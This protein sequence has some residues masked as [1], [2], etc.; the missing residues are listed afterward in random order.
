VTL[1]AHKN[2]S[3]LWL[4]V[5][6][7]V[8]V[9]CSG[10]DEDDVVARAYGNYLYRS[11]IA[12]LVPEG[13][14]AEDSVVIVNNYVNQWL[15]QQVVLEKARKNVKKNFDKELQN[16]KNSLLAY[17][18]EQLVVAE[19]LDTNV[20][21]EE[22][23]SYYNSHQETFVLRFPLVRAIWVKIPDDKESVKKL[24]SLMS[25]SKLSDDDIM[26][27]QR[28]GAT[29]S[30]GA[31]YDMES[32]RPLYKFLSDVPVEAGGDGSW[33][34]GKR[35]VEAADGDC[36]CMAHIFEFRLAGAP[37]PMDYEREAI[38]TVILNKR[39]I[40]IIKSMQRDLLQKAD[41]KGEIEIK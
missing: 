35:L 30:L 21:D 4:C 40:D 29:S 9:A 5:I 39:K 34:Q 13:T 6:A 33:L 24:R 25:N 16:Y 22:I 10:K 20:S 41:A 15:Q 8:L 37:S 18:Y 38:K 12:D 11:D 7:L 27:I 1:S 14:A 17:E 2:L 36:V 3:W 26:A 31:D 28:I 19:L 23:E 32:W